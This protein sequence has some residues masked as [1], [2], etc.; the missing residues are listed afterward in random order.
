[1]V[2]AGLERQSL[3]HLIYIAMINLSQ[4]SDQQVDCDSSITHDA[5]IVHTRDT[6]H[7]MSFHLQHL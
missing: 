1:M 4:H 7:Y 3:E 5:S 2:S 6:N